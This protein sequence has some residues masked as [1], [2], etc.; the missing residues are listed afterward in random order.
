MNITT[1]KYNVKLVVCLPTVNT[2]GLYRKA[3]DKY[4]HGYTEHAPGQ[5]VWQGIREPIIIFEVWCNSFLE[6][7]QLVEVHVNYQNWAE[8]EA[9]ALTINGKPI[10]L[11]NRVNPQEPNTIVTCILANL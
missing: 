9:V 6:L 10:V 7:S 1:Y 3:L 8:Q 5:G 4:A 2:L 11:D